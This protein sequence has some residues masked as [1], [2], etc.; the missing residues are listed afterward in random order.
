LAK[1]PHLIMITAHGREEVHKPAEQAGIEDIL[2]KPLNP[3]LLFDT[4]MHTLAA[5]HPEQ[6]SAVRTDASPPPSELAVL[7]GARVL[8][9][10]DNE[11]N[12]EVAMA[13]LQELGLVVDVAAN[14]RIAVDKVESGRYDVVLMDMQMPVLDGLAAT[15]EIRQLGGTAELPIISMTANALAG[16]RERCIEAG[17]NDHMTKPIDPELLTRKLLQWIGSRRQPVPADA[18]RASA[19]DTEPCGLPFLDGIDGLAPHIGLR[20]AMGQEKLYLSLLDKFVQGES[21]WESRMAKALSQSDLDTARRLAHT[22]KGVSA[23]VGAQKLSSL[24]Q[25]L[26]HAI[27]QQAPEQLI[28]PLLRDAGS[29]LAV[30]VQTLGER[31][32]ARQV[33]SMS[34]SVDTAR[35][36]AL[37]RQLIECFDHDDFAS[38]QL[39]DENSGLLRAVLGAHFEP[40]A[41]AVHD[42]DFGTALELLKTA[43]TSHSIAL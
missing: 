24:A 20:Q 27:K 35:L 10:E 28:G 14:G 31:L 1:L 18:P 32:P 22:L 11:L 42:F 21:D 9:V 36:G 12:Q 5:Q 34:K 23:Q 40:F 19:Q 39:V 8:L 30:L 41:K 3:S 38:G 6:A 7:R 13:F 25:V 15:R 17:M 16:D 43:A 33:A 2:T 26:E 29:H 37:C 4:V